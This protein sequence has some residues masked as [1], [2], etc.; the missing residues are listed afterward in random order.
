M[1]SRECL[2]ANTVVNTDRKLFTVFGVFLRFY[3]N[4]LRASC[5]KKLCVLCS[6]SSA[7]GRQGSGR[8]VLAHHCHKGSGIGG[9]GT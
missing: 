9:E 2:A 6:S 7:E 4:S 5:E 1:F 3:P 8:G